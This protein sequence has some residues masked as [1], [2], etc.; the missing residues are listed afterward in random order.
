M[1]DMGNSTFTPRRKTSRARGYI[2]DYKPQAKT[3]CLLDDALAVLESYRTHWPLTCRQIYYRLIGAYG[4]PKTE[5]FYKKLCHHLANA[6]RGS[7]IDFDAIRDDGIS[8]VS[9]QHFDDEEHFKR[10]VRLLGK[11][12]KRNLLTTQPHHVEVWCEASGMIFQLAEVA[13]EYSIPVYSS[14][15]FDSLT[16]KKELADRI[17][18]IDK[19]T[20]I[21]HLGDYDPSGESIFNSAAED[22]AAFVEWDRTLATTNVRF[23]RVALTAEQ[24]REFKLPTAPAKVSDTRA[25]SW[26]G[27][28]CQ[29][30][31]LPPDQ[32][33][34]LLRKAIVRVTDALQLQQ[35][36]SRES[37]ERVRIAGSLP[38]PRG[39]A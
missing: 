11:R 27:E 25:K 3:R 24:V 36:R 20:I 26:S 28:T 19:P 32:I 12:Y 21:L 5:D 29:L 16:A 18:K 6:R 9:M 13:H 33:A 22:V 7:V 15:G 4:Y 14:S 8:T 10:H 39:A 1:I 2:A 34:G 37:V 38:A 30:E 35:D 31:A 17:C 23:E